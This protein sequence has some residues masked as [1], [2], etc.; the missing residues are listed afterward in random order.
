MIHKNATGARLPD[1]L[2]EQQPHVSQLTNQVCGA[3]YEG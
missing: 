2:T 3:G 1:S